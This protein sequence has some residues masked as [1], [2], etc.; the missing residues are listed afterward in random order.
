MAAPCQ[1]LA[2]RPPSSS[3][4]E[5]S[6]TACSDRRPRAAVFRAIP[7]YV[8]LLSERARLVALVDDALARRQR[9]VDLAPAAG[10]A[11]QVQSLAAHA[12]LLAET[13]HRATPPQFKAVPP[14]SRHCPASP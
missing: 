4:S 3:D 7:H 6:A 2:N 13:A 14:L 8:G 1:A 11:T 10:M 12:G 5:I 9:I